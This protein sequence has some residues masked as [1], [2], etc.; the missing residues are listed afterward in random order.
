MPVDFCR[1]ATDVWL[2]NQCC[3]RFSE[4]GCVFGQNSTTPEI[5]SHN[6]DPDITSSAYH[7]EANLKARITG[8]SRGTTSDT[9]AHRGE[10]L[11]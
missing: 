3:K 5:A 1:V 11:A 2:S 7:Q 6:L 8:A 4:P 9:L 10:T